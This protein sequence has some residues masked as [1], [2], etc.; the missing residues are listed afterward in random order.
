MNLFMSK[1]NFLSKIFL[2]FTLTFSFLL[3]NC[4]SLFSQSAPELMY[5][6]S[7]EVTK[8]STI[9]FIWNKIY[10]NTPIFNLQVSNNSGFSNLLLDVDVATNT[11]TASLPLISGTKYFWRVKSTIGLQVSDWSEVRSFTYFLPT[12]I[13]GLALW[14]DPGIGVQL[15][16]T[17]VQKINDQSGLLNNAEQLNPA[18]QPLFIASDSLINKKPSVKYD[19]VDDFMEMLDNSSLDFSTEMSIHT[20]VKPRVAAVNKTILAKWDYQ[21]QGAWVFQSEFATAD[22]LMFSPCAFITDP[23][24]QKVVSGNADMISQKPAVLTLTYNGNQ[25]TKVKYY[26]NLNLLTASTVGTIPSSMP[27]CSATLKVGKYGGIATRYYDGDIVEVLIYNNVLS[28]S[29]RNLV[30]TYLRYKYAPPVSLGPDTLFANNALCGNIKLKAQSRYTTYLWSTGATTSSINVNTLGT[31]WVR[32]TDFLGNIS[33]DTIR[34]LPPFEM[35]NPENSNI[36]LNSSIQWETNYPS[37]QFTYL[38]QNGLTTPIQNIAAPGDYFVKVTD[39]N[40]CFIYSDTITFSI[41]TYTNTAFLGADT[42]LCAGNYLGLQ[43]GAPETVAYVWGD[44]SSNSSLLVNTTGT[45]AVQTTNINGCVAQD[46][47]N[48]NIIGVAPLA[49]FTTGNQC[50]QTAVVFADQ[51]APVGASPIDGWQWDFGDGQGF[52]SSQSPSYTYTAPGTYTIQLYVSQGGCGAYHYDTVQVYANPQVNYGFTGHC[53]GATIQFSNLSVAGGSPIQSYAWDFDMPSTGA[54][55]TSTIPVPNRIFANAGEYFVSLIITDG[56]GCKDSI[57]QSVLIDPTPQTAIDVINSC[58]LT[59]ADIV[60]L[61]PTETGLMY[62]WIFGDNS[63]SIL[64][65]PV[66][67]YDLYGTYI[68]TLNVTNTFGCVG[69]ESEDIVVYPKPNAMMDL[70][71]AC[72]GSFG[73]LSD[74]STVISGSL[75]SSMWIINA[76]DTIYGMNT[77]YP[78]SSL[79]QQQVELT[80][81]SVEG[82]SATANQF[83]DITETLAASFTSATAIVAAGD[84]IAFTNTSQGNGIYLWNF[85]DNSFSSQTNPS[86]IYGDAYI[87]STLTISLISMNLSG[88]VDTTY[89]SIQVLEPSLDLEL[90][91][92]Y[93]DEVDG[94]N[95]IGVKL[96]NTGSA[97]ITKAKLVLRSQK[98]LLF[99]E[100]WEG[101]LHPQEDSIYVFSAKPVAGFSDQDD[102]DAFYCVDGIGFS[103][104][105]QQEEDLSNNSV[106]KDIEGQN[107]IL[108]PIYPN[109]IDDVIP[110]LIARFDKFRGINRFN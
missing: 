88:C 31:Y 33:S 2:L 67:T 23:G 40:G 79:G 20:L 17:K 80:T 70:G 108:Q 77:A 21:T 58:Q 99:N 69:T 27:N 34:V 50:D 66:K 76:T 8:E 75:D 107:V 74:M 6:N 41:D 59:P 29:L 36:C 38:W 63:F 44:G 106:C 102:Q 39:V 84:P 9:T 30:D 82:C 97:D 105:G 16:G 96:K 87:D 52:S 90:S 4:E 100:L 103:A 19:G 26:K 64:P 101:V 18:Q 104:N 25:S 53:Q 42:S 57:V 56:N 48:V 22:E 91:E 11:H 3:G 94:W 54:Y 24:N 85:G 95:V 1:M 93:I 49:Q 68:V 43:V 73:T 28:D 65:N 5:P 51:S 83:F 55:N 37:S 60:N 89:Q 86:H 110:Y 72:V 46:T 62:N 98:G 92:F 61:T 32:V 7:L 109:P 47:I 12:S 10:Y 71:P 35:N 81:Y 15:N 78:W 13:S 45:Y 14:L